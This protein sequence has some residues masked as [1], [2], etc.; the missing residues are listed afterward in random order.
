MPAGSA[1]PI[2]ATPVEMFG[3]YRPVHLM[4]LGTID[5]KR[6]CCRGAQVGFSNG[7]R[8]CDE[9]VVREPLAPRRVLARFH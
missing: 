5:G 4:D 3:I 6:S 9:N 8:R 1:D 7:R 2:V